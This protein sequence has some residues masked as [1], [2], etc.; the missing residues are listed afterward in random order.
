VSALNSCCPSSKRA[1]TRVK[2]IAQSLRWSTPRLDVNVE[3]LVLHIGI[4]LR[5][6]ELVDF[7]LVYQV[8]YL[9]LDLLVP[10]SLVAVVAVQV[11]SAGVRGEGINRQ[12]A[13]QAKQ[14]D[15]RRRRARSAQAHARRANPDTQSIAQN[16][17]GCLDPLPSA[18]AAG[19]REPGKQADARR[20][21]T[22]QARA[23]ALSR[24]A[25][26]ASAHG[27]GAQA[28]LC[29]LLRRVLEA[30]LEVVDHA[31]PVSREPRCLPAF[32]LPFGMR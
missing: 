5:A 2:S 32:V 19:W 15:A 1:R 31:A 28:H 20:T 9:R 30:L 24:Q 17:I 7:S 27:A 10:L 22:A 14:A 6:G 13:K 16:A 4:G 18:A 23:R 29:T 21:R 25:R 26:Q 11:L 8:P 3:H 12:A